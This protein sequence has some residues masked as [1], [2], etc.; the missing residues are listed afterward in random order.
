[1]PALVYSLCV[2]ASAICAG[3]LL[4]AYFRT[5]TKLLLWSGAAFT[6]LG[7]NNIFVLGDAVLFPD[8]N[9]LP[10]RYIAA[11]AAVCIMIYGFIW[12]AE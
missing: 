6:C 1:M 10:F 5:R 4:R 7:I 12:E 8:L 3:L 9:L 2:V 11:L